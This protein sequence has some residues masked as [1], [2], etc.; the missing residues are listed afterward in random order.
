MAASKHRNFFWT[1]FLCFLPLYNGFYVPGVAPHEFKDGDGIEVKAIK[2]TSVKAVVPYEYYSIPFCRP[3]GE[4]HYK[5]ENLGEVMRG[6]RIVNTPYEVFMKKD[7]TYGDG[8]EVKAIKLTSVKA[9]VPYEYYSIPFCRPAGELHY[10]SENLGEVMRGDRI[11]N[12]P[13]EVFMKKDET[14]KSL[15]SATKNPVKSLNTEESE[16]LQKRIA[17]DYHVHLLIDNLPVATKYQVPE[18]GEIFYDHGYKLGW[19]ENDKLFVNNHLEILL[20]YHEPQPNVFRV[21]GFEV[22]PKSIASKKYTFTDNG[23][24]SFGDNSDPQEVTQGSNQIAFTYSIRWE[25]SEIP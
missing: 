4:L 8:I 21:V 6:D 3:A 19:T 10:K 2:L 15:C 14:C 20:K 13:Y 24:C 17:E 11:V 5:S 18:T 16:Q 25:S 1:L 9:V 22:Q 23:K 12:T 7:E